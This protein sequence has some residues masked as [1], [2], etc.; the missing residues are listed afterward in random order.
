MTSM[1]EAEP[2][3]A[4]PT[5]EKIPCSRILNALTYGP[6]SITVVASYKL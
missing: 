3:N 2:D 6:A 5:T 1:S 4:R